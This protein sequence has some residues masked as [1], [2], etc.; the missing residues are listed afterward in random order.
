MQRGKTL[1]LPTLHYLQAM[2]SNNGI[3]KET[4]EVYNFEGNEYQLINEWCHDRPQC[5]GIRIDFSPRLL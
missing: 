2:L 5:D 1:S 4:W 3:Y